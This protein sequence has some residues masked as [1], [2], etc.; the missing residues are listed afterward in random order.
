M[1]HRF[2][3]LR[4]PELGEIMQAKPLVI[5]PVGQTEEHGPH[6]PINTDT[7][8]ASRLA[9]AIA[10]KVGEEGSVLLLDSIAYGYSGKVMSQWPGTIRVNM[11]II[12]DYVYDV[13]ASLVDMGASKIA[14]INGHGHHCALLELM[15]RKLAD[16]KAVAPMILYPFGL[17]CEGI[18]QAARGGSGAS[19]H[20]GEFEASLMLFLQPECVDMSRAV[21]NPWE[22][23]DKFPPK[24]FW[25]TWD[26]QKTDSGIYGK[27]SVASREAGKTFFDTAV[28]KA[29]QCLQEYCR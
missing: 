3:T 29:S 12:R 14:V 10:E 9:Q 1:W 27:P 23:T 21:D 22:D 17:A 6:L 4:S 11:D 7:V 24:T 19:C 13:C 20:A 28:A 16:E 8:I 18:K 2:G 25:S 26:R 15:A 5:L